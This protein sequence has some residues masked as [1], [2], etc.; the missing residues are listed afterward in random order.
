MIIVSPEAAGLVRLLQESGYR[1][2]VGPSLPGS[3]GAQVLVPQKKVALGW[4]ASEAEA[5]ATARSLRC[6]FGNGYT[7]FLVLALSIDDMES[8]LAA[9]QAEVLTDRPGVGLGRAPVRRCVQVVPCGS[10]DELLETALV[11]LEAVLEDPNSEGGIFATEALDVGARMAEALAVMVPGEE[12]RVATARAFLAQ[13]TMAS[14]AELAVAATHDGQH[15]PDEAMLASALADGL[16]T[17]ARERPNG[18]NSS[19]SASE[20]LSDLVAVASTI[21]EQLAATDERLAA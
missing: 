15:T 19:Q 20:T 13:F 9:V 4:A 10:P 8:V 21:T 5:M 11:A 7:R 1:A 18:V 17:D 3:G 6:E 14:L 12:P 16:A 2:R